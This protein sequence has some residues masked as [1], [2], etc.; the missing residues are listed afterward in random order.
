MN[1]RYGAHLWLGD[2]ADSYPQAKNGNPQIGR[3]RRSVGQWRLLDNA[4]AS[5]LDSLIS[6]SIRASGDA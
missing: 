2:V 5:L 6:G 1:V 4:M 3:F